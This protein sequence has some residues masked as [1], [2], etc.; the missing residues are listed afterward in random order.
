MLENILSLP[1]EQKIGQL[2]FIGIPGAEFDDNTREILERVLPGGICLFARNIREAEQTRELINNVNDFLQITP[3]IS[4]DQEGGLV[5]RLRRVAEPMPSASSLKT[6]EQAEIL[7]KVTA[8]IIKIL[9]FNMNFAPVVDVRTPERERF[10]NGL[11]SRTFG[12][13]KVEVVEFAQRY[14]E[15]FQRNGVIGCLKHFPGLGA[16][17]VDSHEE[18]PLVNLDFETINEIDLFPYREFFKTGEV[19]LVMTAHAAFPLCDLQERDQ[20]GKL[21]PSSLSFNFTTKLLRETLGFDGIAITD[22]LEMGAILKNYGIGEACKM[23]IKAGQNLLAICNNSDAIVEGYETVFEAVKSGEIEEG[24]IN[25]S[26]RRISAIKS[27]IQPPFEFNANRLAELSGEIVA[28]KE[29][30][31]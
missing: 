24:L 19:K 25:E 27:L 2:F 6:P 15:T 8:E 11:V 26:L 31:K 21:L 30:L 3:F 4:L 10:S 29:Q 18:L 28:L 5:D 16:T 1:L 20:N 14:L 12:N 13:S 23:A 9:G 7:A 17:E 22:D